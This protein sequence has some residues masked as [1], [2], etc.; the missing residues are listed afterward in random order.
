MRDVAE[1]AGVST[2]AVSYAI[3]GSGRVSPAVAARVRETASTLGY[4]PSRSALA[5][6]TGRSGILACVV[7]TL[8]SPVFPEIAHAVQAAAAMRGLATLLVDAGSDPSEELAALALLARQGVDGAVVVLS[9]DIRVADLPMLPMVTLDSPLGDLPCVRA[10]HRAGG[11]LAAQ[12]LADRGHRRVGLLSGDPGVFSSRERRA[13]FL[14]AASGGLEVIW[15]EIVP[16][17]PNLP[18][19]VRQR[20]AGT[21]VTAVACVNDVVAIG[22]LGALRAA[23]RP[24]PGDVAVIGFDDIALAAWPLVDLTTVRQP[25]TDLAARAVDLLINGSSQ[26]EEIVLDVQVIRRSS[27]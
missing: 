3:N 24:V 2:A 17:L 13:G 11:L 7:P 8:A 1:A 10:D 15:D 22:A 20:L 25:I 19:E 27:A 21:D 6:R 23:G 18:V 5:L 12:Y 9:P 14:N 16:L 26:S 4:T